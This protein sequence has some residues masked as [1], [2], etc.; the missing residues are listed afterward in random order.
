MSDT[1]APVHL[2]PGTVIA[3]FNDMTPVERADADHILGRLVGDGSEFTAIAVADS[4]P[5][6]TYLLAVSLS[7]PVYVT[8]AYEG[9]SDGKPGIITWAGRYFDARHYGSSYL[10]F[11]EAC[12]DIE[13]RQA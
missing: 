7:R 9:R 1:I 10:A 3:G 6:G 2:E 8:W 11:L 5:S 13:S 4:N 12:R